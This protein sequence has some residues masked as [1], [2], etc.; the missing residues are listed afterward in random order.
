[1]KKSLCILLVMVTML[2]L[3]AC[4]KE[5]NLTTFNYEDYFYL[6][7]QYAISDQRAQGSYRTG[8]GLILVSLNKFDTANVEVDY[9]S[10]EVSL[11]SP[12]SIDGRTKATVVLEPVGGEIWYAKLECEAKWILVNTRFTLNRSDITVKVKEIVGVAKE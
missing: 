9:I 8:E 10:V 11:E 1:M 5:T 7:V 12:W 2:S 3:C 6:D 4:E